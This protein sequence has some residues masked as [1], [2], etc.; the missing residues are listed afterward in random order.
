MTAMPNLTRFV[1]GMGLGAGSME[2]RFVCFTFADRQYA[3]DVDD[4]FGIY[5]GSP[6]IP[7]PDLPDCMDGEISPE[8]QRIPILNLRRFLDLRDTYAQQPPWVLAVSDLGGPVGLI[9]D[10]VNEV[11]RLQPSE[12]DAVTEPAEIPMG[13][14]VT[15]C[16]HRNGR[17]LFMPDF[18]RILQDALI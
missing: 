8:G 12:I 1:A 14:Y 9:V 11:V 7:T 16:S 10:R 17:W 15:R 2:C 13:R 18:H 6:V 5:H 4:V 3:I